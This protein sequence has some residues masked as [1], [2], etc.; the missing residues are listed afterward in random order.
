MATIVFKVQ[1]TRIGSID[2]P[3]GATVATALDKLAKAG[4]DV[5]GG[6]GGGGRCDGS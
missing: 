2:L 4:L 5:S 1:S 3:E 6:Q